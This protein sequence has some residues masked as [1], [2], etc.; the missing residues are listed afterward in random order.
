METTTAAT[1]T[2]VTMET[3]SMEA[4]LGAL[5]TCRRVTREARNDSGAETI[6]TC[7]AMDTDEF[8]ERPPQSTDSLNLFSQLKQ[9]K[10]SMKD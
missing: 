10:E 8:P 4:C 2:V 9:Q 7:V 3:A 5:L 6:G 1:G